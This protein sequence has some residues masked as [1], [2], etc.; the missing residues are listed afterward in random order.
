[1]V[2]SSALLVTLPTKDI[3][4]GNTGQNMQLLLPASYKQNCG[5]MQDVLYYYLVRDNSHSH[6]SKAPKQVYDSLYGN[7]NTVIQ[8]LKRIDMNTSE[9]D[10]YINLAKLSW[11]KK[12]F[13]AAAEF[14]DTKSVV[15]FYKE[16]KNVGKIG[17]KLRIQ[18]AVFGSKV[19]SK[20]YHVFK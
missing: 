18:R 10:K 8:T 7:E 1:M 9:R 12:R 2:R 6:S 20:I 17:F 5:F 16:M 4:C 19:F 3:F 11:A 15:E 14:Q 13:Y